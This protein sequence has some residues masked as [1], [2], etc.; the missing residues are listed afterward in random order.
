M[1]LQKTEMLQEQ[2]PSSVRNGLSR[3]IINKKIID[4]YRI[5]FYFNGNAIQLECSKNELKP[6]TEGTSQSMIKKLWESNR[7]PLLSLAYV[8]C[9]LFNMILQKFDEMEKEQEYLSIVEVNFFYLV[10]EYQKGSSSFYYV[11]KAITQQQPNNRPK[12]SQQTFPHSIFQNVE[13]LNMLHNEKFEEFQRLLNI[14]SVFMNFAGQFNLGLAEIDHKLQNLSTKKNLFYFTIE[15][16]MHYE[17]THDFQLMTITKDILYQ[18]TV[19]PK[20]SIISSENF[21]IKLSHDEMAFVLYDN[22]RE[23]GGTGL[24]KFLTF[25]NSIKATPLAE[26]LISQENMIKVKYNE[27]KDLEIFFNSY[28]SYFASFLNLKLNQKFAELWHS[29]C[30][31]NPIADDK[32]PKIE[33]I[34]NSGSNL[35]T[36]FKVTTINY[37]L[38]IEKNNL[39][40]VFLPVAKL[41]NAFENL[42][43]KILNYYNQYEQDLIYENFAFFHSILLELDDSPEY[44]RLLEDFITSF[45]SYRSRNSDKPVKSKIRMN[46]KRL[47]KV[48]ACKSSK[49]NPENSIELNIKV[50]DMNYTMKTI[51]TRSLSNK[52]SENRQE[53]HL[54]SK[55]GSKGFDK[56]DD[57]VGF[58]LDKTPTELFHILRKKT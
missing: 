43:E 55:E 1:D 38:I 12:I 2:L 14:H 25:Y 31:E 30:I 5:V 4:K 45:E 26:N 50:Y 58:V 41:K 20:S 33:C 23:K 34:K 28:L 18:G 17:L 13:L 15:S 52:E 9:K 16:A 8:G 10:I 27:Q 24:C 42:K 51:I 48:L 39:K 54:K 56:M 7:E 57:L 47:Y 19:K 29:A 46:F 22:H 32:K 11:I 44:T 53:F 6:V 40:N 36:S 21:K 3:L 37:E 49:K 35:P